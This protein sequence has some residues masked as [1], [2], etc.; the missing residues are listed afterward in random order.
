[1]SPSPP[2]AISDEE[3][4]QAADADDEA[5]AAAQHDVSIPED[6]ADDA[7]DESEHSPVPQVQR[8]LSFESL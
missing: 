5:D 4:E 2:P 1:M 7:D 8:D 6:P 3:S